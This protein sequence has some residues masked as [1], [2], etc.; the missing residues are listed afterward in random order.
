MGGASVELPAFAMCIAGEDE[1]IRRR[2][3]EGRA[4]IG[5]V[6][7]DHLSRAGKALHGSAQACLQG[8]KQRVQ[9]WRGQQTRDGG[10]R[11]TGS[12][13]VDSVAEREREFALFLAEKRQHSVSTAQDDLQIT[14]A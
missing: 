7:N 8:M 10:E 5:L 6:G 14:A 4:V 12:V 1:V 9:L 11:E 2:E 13:N 3:E